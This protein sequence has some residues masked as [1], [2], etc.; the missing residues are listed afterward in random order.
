LILEH[1]VALLELRDTLLELVLLVEFGGN[2]AFSACN[3][4][5]VSS[6]AA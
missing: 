1:F 6:K 4:R 3:C 2:C 5:N